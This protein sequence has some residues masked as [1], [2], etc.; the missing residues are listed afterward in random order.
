MNQANYKLRHILYLMK[1]T[2]WFKFM[3]GGSKSFNLDSF[4]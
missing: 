3:F 4:R 1:I 2:L